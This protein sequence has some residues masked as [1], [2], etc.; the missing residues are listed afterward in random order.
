MTAMLDHLRAQRVLRFEKG[1]VVLSQPLDEIELGV[2]DELAQIIELQLDRLSEEDRR[3]LEAGSIAGTVFP[4]WAVSASLKRETEDVEEAY[5]ALVRRVRL[6]SIAG[7]DELPDG[8][9]STFYV[10]SH[11]LYREV[12]YAKM[13]AGRRSRWH[14]RVADR[15]RAMFAGNEASV[16]HEIASH[17][18]AGRVIPAA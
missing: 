12:L 16:A 5:V 15:L 2:P 11:A 6:L 4:S 7:H 9:C 18:E 13:P 1:D 3:L 14:M 10:F 17:T 8:S